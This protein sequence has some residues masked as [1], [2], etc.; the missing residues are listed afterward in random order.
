MI[1]IGIGL[2]P[3]LRQRRNAPAPAR[4]HPPVAGLAYTAYSKTIDEIVADHYAAVAAGGR[5]LM[6]ASTVLMSTANTLAVGGTVGTI[7][8]TLPGRVD[9]APTVGTGWVNVGGAFSA[10]VVTGNGFV[11]TRDTAGGWAIAN[12]GN[13]VSTVGGDIFEVTIV[14]TQNTQTAPVN[15]G[16]NATTNARTDGCSIIP[17]GAT[18]T[19]IGYMRCTANTAPNLSVWLGTIGVLAV[20][21]MTVRKLG[22]L[23]WAQVTASAR[24]ILRQDE[25]GV[26]YLEF[27]SARVLNSTTVVHGAATRMWTAVGETHDY[28]NLQWRL[29]ASAAN[30]RLQVARA[31][32]VLSAQHAGSAT[33]AATLPSATPAR[34]PWVV[35]GDIT[36][37]ANK[38]SLSVPGATVTDN[39]AVVSV[40]TNYTTG[41][42][43]VGRYSASEYLVGRVYR[44]PSLIAGYLTD[45]QVASVLA[46][47]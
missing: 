5:P 7:L 42:M 25:A 16:L 10:F 11:A 38:T 40:A 41:G 14:V 34:V 43:L 18:G 31:A 45:E 39:T 32:G 12:S 23:A 8:D 46:A 28:D 9:G 3:I 26:H 20:E 1:G 2:V 17:A 29:N 4:M 30:G 44:L 19:F 36:V 15:L 24:P 22:G 21:S 37:G 27:T 33:A 6:H 47:Y 35:R 13:T